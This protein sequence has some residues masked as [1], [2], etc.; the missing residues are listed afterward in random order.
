M[1]LPLLRPSVFDAFPDVVAAFSTRAGGVIAYVFGW[2][3]GLLL[4]LAERED[5]PLPRE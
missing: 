5:L 2:L 3:T 4:L 1:P